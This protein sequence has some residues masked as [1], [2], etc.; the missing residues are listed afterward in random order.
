MNHRALL[1]SPQANPIDRAVAAVD[2]EIANVQTRLDTARHYKA[3]AVTGYEAKL[4]RLHTAR[5]ALTNI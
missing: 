1:N 5:E 4:V 2:L 3:T